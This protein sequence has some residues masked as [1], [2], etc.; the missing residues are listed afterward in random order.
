MTTNP[1]PIVVA[2]FASLLALAGFLAI[3][4]YTP[5]VYI[6][7]VIAVSGQYPKDKNPGGP[8][9]ILTIQ[10][11]AQSQPIT[12]LSATLKFDLGP[13]ASWGGGSSQVVPSISYHT[14]EFPSV[15]EANPILPGGWVSQ[16]YGW[17]GPS[18]MDDNV[19]VSGTLADGSKFS[20]ETNVN[21]VK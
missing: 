1:R 17:V 15:T 6:P 20:V 11:S 2:A 12:Q 16:K 5:P 14:L 3:T 21:W 8:T 4:L 18:G 9:I 13:F 19:T 10:T 7:P